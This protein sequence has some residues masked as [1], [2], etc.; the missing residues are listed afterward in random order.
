MAPTRTMSFSAQAS[1]VLLLIATATSDGCSSN[2]D[3]CSKCVGAGVPSA[4]VD[5]LDGGAPAG[6]A[7]TADITGGKCDAPLV[8]QT[9]SVQRSYP[10]PGGTLPVGRDIMIELVSPGPPSGLSSDA[11][12]YIKPSSVQVL[13]WSQ[14]SP[15]VATTY[16]SHEGPTFYLAGAAASW[17]PPSPE[18]H[19]QR[20]LLLV[21]SLVDENGTPLLSPNEDYELSFELSDTDSTDD[22]AE[23]YSLSFTVVEEDPPTTSTCWGGAPNGAFGPAAAHVACSSTTLN[24]A[25][26]AEC[27]L[28]CLPATRTLAEVVLAPHPVPCPYLK[29]PDQPWLWRY[30]LLDP[31]GGI[32]HES[33]QARFPE[34]NPTAFA[35]RVSLVSAPDDPVPYQL[36]WTTYRDQLSNDFIIQRSLSTV[37]AKGVACTTDPQ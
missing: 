35:A 9:F 2:Q 20:Y 19:F 28:N 25:S 4:A 13:P 37:F 11:V 24:C 12:A 26:N 31:S 7:F 36:E 22:S 21:V 6:D 8:T 30:R 5:A 27:L 29:S 16:S 18:N 3:A 1:T 14:E 23:I 34:D 32:I 10:Q 17:S 15:P 33:V